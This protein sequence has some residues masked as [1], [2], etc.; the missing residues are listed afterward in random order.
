MIYQWDLSCSYGTPM[1]KRRLTARLRPANWP[2]GSGPR[3][4]ICSGWDGWCGFEA[5]VCC[6]HIVP[7]FPG[8]WRTFHW[9]PFWWL[10]TWRCWYAWMTT[11]WW[12]TQRTWWTTWRGRPVDLLSHTQKKFKKIKK[13]SIQCLL[14]ILRL[15]I[16]ISF[17]F[18]SVS[19]L[20]LEPSWT[21]LKWFLWFYLHVPNPLTPLDQSLLPP[22]SPS[23]I[24]S[25]S[26]GTGPSMSHTRP[27]PPWSTFLPSQVGVAAS[28]SRNTSDLSCSC[29]AHL[30]SCSQAIQL[31]WTTKSLRGSRQKPSGTSS[32]VAP[33]GSLWQA[34]PRPW[35]W[36]QL[37]P[38]S[39]SHTPADPSFCCQHGSWGQLGWPACWQWEIDRAVGQLLEGIFWLFP[40]WS[41]YFSSLELGRNNGVGCWR[42]TF[43]LPPQLCR[44][45]SGL[46]GDHQLLG[47]HLML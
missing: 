29:C 7:T 34:V 45:T 16:S 39:M 13:Y 41:R 15:L 11:P 46:W 33:D 27:A 4:H 18:S 20:S 8:H 26:S 14:S 47:A 19:Y 9:P 3:E 28:F 31:S 6:L 44:H 22:W 37:V 1:S 2:N 21:G 23:R 36:L 5:P 10:R 43:G 30:N 42:G 40:S 32:P 35:L 38:H 17:C 24:W 12:M 25:V